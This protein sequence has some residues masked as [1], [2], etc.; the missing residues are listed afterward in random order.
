MPPT[1][2]AERQNGWPLVE[3]SSSS[4]SAPCLLFKFC[5][6]LAA[7]GTER[8]VSNPPRSHKEPELGRTLAV[9]DETWTFRADW[10]MAGR[11]DP[12]RGREVA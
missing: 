1:A 4:L 6:T 10:L 2:D 5:T 8:A 9:L 7:S 12:D 11:F 3:L